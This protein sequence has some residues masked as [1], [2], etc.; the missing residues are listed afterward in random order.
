MLMPGPMK[1]FLMTTA[2]IAAL[3]GACNTDSLEPGPP[4]STITVNLHNDGGTALY[5]FQNC[6]LDYTITS[7]ADPVHVVTREG[8]CGCD[9]GQSSCP[10]CGPCFAGPREVVAGSVL[11]DSWTTVSVTTEST[12][13]GSCERKRALPYGA[14]R[15]DVPVYPSADDALAKTSARTATQS[16]ALPLRGDALDVLLGVSP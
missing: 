7:L 10:L 14:Y 11:T 3:A 15:I 12:P 9:C 13:T 5:L 2:V 16:F 8:P 1:T 6:L 4:A